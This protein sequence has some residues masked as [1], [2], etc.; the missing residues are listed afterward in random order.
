MS[1]LALDASTY[2][3][4]LAVLE[5]ARVVARARAEMRGADAERLMPAVAA[6]L[7]EAAVT[8]AALE[9]IVCGA[10]PG[11][12]TSLRIAAAITK[13]LAFGADVP[14]Y[15]VS[16]LGLI[17]AGS[18]QTTGPGRYVAA[19]DALRGEHY[20]AICTVGASGDVVAVGPAERWASE[21][22]ADRAAPI[23]PLLGPGLAVDAMPDV[24]GVRR[25]ASLPELRTPVDLATWE[26]DYGRLA[27]A[28]VKWE[29]VHGR[30]LAVP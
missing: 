29:A 4:S 27:E 7:D 6:M 28:Q 2:R 11:S 17:V 23:G 21:T 3:A 15:A 25:M 1:V 12:F 5:G 30:P 22:L 19:V 9:R 26:P 20:V 16:S 18:D 24:A 14:V 8:P 10:G 13:G